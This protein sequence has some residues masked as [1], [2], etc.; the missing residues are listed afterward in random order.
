MYTWFPYNTLTWWVRPYK[1][2][3]LDARDTRITRDLTMTCVPSE[4]LYGFRL[5][6]PSYPGGAC[7][8]NG[9]SA[10]DSVVSHQGCLPLL[11][12]STGLRWGITK[13][14]VNRVISSGVEKSGCEPEARLV[15]GQTHSTALRSAQGDKEGG[16]RVWFWAGPP[17]GFAQGRL[18]DGAGLGSEPALNIVEGVTEGLDG[19]AF[20][21]GHGRLWVG[22]VIWR[23]SGRISGFL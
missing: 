15:L 11:G 6:L 21:G 5:T 4:I 2:P 9:S 13:K 12:L 18:F 10:I 23:R 20:G 8:R 14:A 1:T 19:W 17:F 16:R 3:A 22:V 7:G